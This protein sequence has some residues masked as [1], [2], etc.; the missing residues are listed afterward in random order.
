M[1]RRT[2]QQQIARAEETIR[3]ASAKLKAQD[4]KRDTR[5]KIIL[6]AT[7]LSLAETDP[8][9]ERIISALVSRMS[10]R[11]RELFD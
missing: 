11:D 2:P 5:R 1:T 4:R 8:K 9:A 10:D 6:G 7:L 3:R